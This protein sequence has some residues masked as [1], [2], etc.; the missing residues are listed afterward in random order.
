WA[1]NALGRL[2]IHYGGERYPE[3]RAALEESLAIFRALG[4]LDGSAEVLNH[5]AFIEVLRGDLAQSE[6]LQTESLR[7]SRAAQNPFRTAWALA[8]L[9]HLAFLHGDEARGSAL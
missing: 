8:F 1:L 4:D 6:M 7:D 5:L 9:A 3:R 2:S